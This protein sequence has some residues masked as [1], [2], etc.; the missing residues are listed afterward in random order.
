MA[1]FAFLQLNDPDP[2]VWLVAYGLVAFC[3]AAPS[4]R[5]WSAPCTWLAGGVLLTLALIA[6][7]GF[8]DYLLSGDLG[9]IAGEMSP[10]Q[11]HVEPA[12]EFLGVLIAALILIGTHR[13]SVRSAPP[14][15]E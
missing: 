15:R 13:S 8:I 12:R 9:S 6:L 11:P 1:G 2:L 10:D 4:D 14:D 3:V 7:P 5:V